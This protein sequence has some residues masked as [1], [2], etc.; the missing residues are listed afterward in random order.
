[1]EVFS[2]EIGKARSLLKNRPFRRLWAAQFCAVAAVY[3]LSLAGVVLVEERTHSSAQ[4]GLVILSSILPAF[5]G[6][7]VAGAA[8]D[9]W[10]R[11]RVLMASHLTR[12]LVALAFWAGTRLLHPGFALPMVYAVNVAAALF[13][14]F[15][16]P[17]EMAL[18]PD[19]VGR[20]RLVPANTLFQLGTLV[21]EGLG[22]VRMGPRVIKLAGAPAVGLG[23]A[24]L[25]LLAL[26]LVA[27]LPRDRSSAAQTGEGWAGWAALGSD[28]QAGWRTIA[29][30]H[31]LRLVVLQA[32][33]AA[34]LLLV[35]VSLGPGLVSRHLGMEVEDAALLLLP[36]GVGFL[37]GSFLVNRWEAWLNRQGWIAVGLIVAGL[38]IGLLAAL[39]GGAGWVRLLLSLVPVLGVGLAMA[40]VIIPARTVLQERPSAAVRGRVIAAQLALGNAAAVVPLLM[41]GA[42]A[43][44]L[45]IRP[46]LGLLGLLAVGVGVAGLRYVR[47]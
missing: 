26:I 34:A 41:G 7:L 27:T 43:D 32:T 24:L 10:G 22:V 35:L 17:A 25:C 29:Q 47:E 30:D 21:A 39:A 5:L 8:V 20:A 42:L 9:R 44:S 15:A 33:L 3:G 19:W 40:L 31:Q 28:L 18:L 45:G 2:S 36:G 37:L 23:G 6:S 11:V 14:Q 1:M 12:S 46:V 4:T 38:N 13:S 16:T